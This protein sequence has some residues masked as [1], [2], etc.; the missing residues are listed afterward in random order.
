MR[1]HSR[2]VEVVDGPL[3]AQTILPGGGE[4]PRPAL[5]TGDATPSR[6]RRG[7]PRP[8]SSPPRRPTRR[9]TAPPSSSSPSQPPGRPGR[10]E[11]RALEQA[12]HEHLR[13]DD[14]ERAAAVRVLAVDGAGLPRRDGPRRRLG[15]P[16]RSGWST[17][18]TSTARARAI[19]MLPSAFA[20]PVRRRRA[21]GGVR[22]LR[23]GR[24]DRRAH[25]RARP[26]GARPARP[27]PG[28]DHARRRRDRHRAARR[29]DDRGHRRR[30][31]ADRQR[32][33]LL[34]RHRDLPR[35]LRPAPRAASG[36]PRSAPGARPSPSW[37][38][39]AGSAWCT[40]PR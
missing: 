40:A 33:H 15:R 3:A 12:H 29:G 8:T 35:D 6:G 30:G 39:T 20:G 32:A 31:R 18:T 23:A 36:R 17:S 21:G 26:G 1:C 34:R 10:R 25:R 13:E 27:G 38:P 9:S 16:R 28:A 22:H 4:P 7:P 24:R 2:Q 14:P 37:C 11:R 19:L 5:W